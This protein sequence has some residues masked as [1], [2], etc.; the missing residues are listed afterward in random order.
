[1]M[2]L[3]PIED[4]AH[5][6][7]VKAIVRLQT[8][9]KTLGVAAELVFDVRLH[10]RQ[11]GCFDETRQLVRAIGVQMPISTLALLQQC[12]PAGRQL[13]TDMGG[14]ASQNVVEKIT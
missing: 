7:H 1:M 12:A 13:L 2:V 8:R 10:S 11:V 4:L 9:Q 14:N 6:V 5:Q 3:V